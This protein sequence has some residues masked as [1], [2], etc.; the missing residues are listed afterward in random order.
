[1]PADRKRH[2]QRINV[3]T[4]WPAL[5]SQPPKKALAHDS[6]PLS[7]RRVLATKQVLQ[8]YRLRQAK[9]RQHHH[10]KGQGLKG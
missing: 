4:H 3:C 2:P 6:G 8:A 1:M 7:Y 5:F 9:T 10:G